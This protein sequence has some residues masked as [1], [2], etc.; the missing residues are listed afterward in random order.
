MK[1]NGPCNVDGLR[2]RRNDGSLKR[3]VIGVLIACVAVTVMTAGATTLT[4]TGG[5]VTANWSDADNWDTG[6]T[7]I[8][9]VDLIFDGTTQQENVNDIGNS[10]LSRISSLTVNVDGFIISGNPLELGG[11][12]SV[13]G[14]TTWAINSTL[15]QAISITSVT[16][17]T[18]TLS[19]TLN[20]N[21]YLL[22]LLGGGNFTFSGAISGSGGLTLNGT[23]TATLS[24]A[25]SFSGLTTIAS[26][27]LKM[28]VA[29]AI[30]RLTGFTFNY[31]NC[32][33]AGGI[34]DLNGYNLSCN[35]V[36]GYGTVTSSSG[37]PVLTVGSSESAYN[38]DGFSG[39]ITGPVVLT[40]DG[41]N[42]FYLDGG[43]NNVYTGNTTVS[44]GTLQ[45]RAANSIARGSG[46]GNLSISS[47]A[48]LDLKGW[49]TGVNGLSGAGQ[50]I[51]SSDATDAIFTV[52]NGNATSVFPGIMDD[53][54]GTFKVALTKTGTGALTLS[55]V[56]NYRGAT[57]VGGGQLVVN[58]SLSSASAVAVNAG[59]TLSGNGT[60]GGTV[61][62]ANST[63]AVLYPNSSSTLTVGGNT[64]FN[65][66]NS[67]T[68]FDLSSSAASGND[69]VVLQSQT[70]AITGSPHV[71]INSAGSLDT[72]DYVLFDAG[73]SG[74][75]SG[76]FNTI[77]TWTG[78]TPKFAA[79]YTVT[80]V[81][82]TV[83]LHYTTIPLTVTA[84][85][86][87][88]TYDGNTSASA[89]PTRTSGTLDSGDTGSFTESYDTPNVGSSKTL[90]PTGTIKDAGN[91]DVTSR[92][93]I[94]WTAANV[95]TITAAITPIIVSGSRIYNGL[96]T[97]QAS[98]LTI[99][100][101][102][103]GAN[104][105]LSGTA[106]LASKS[107][108]AQAVSAGTLALGG[109]AA[110]NYTLVGMSGS[111]TITAKDA[112]LT[113]LGASDKF[114][115]GTTTATL[116]GTAA[117]TS[118]DIVSGDDVSLV[119]GVTP[120]GAFVDRELGNA[121]SVPYS[122][123]FSLSGTD[124][125]NYHLVLQSLTA[126]IVNHKEDSGTTTITSA[127]SSTFD[128]WLNNGK[129]LAD[130]SP[131]GGSINGAG[132][133][134]VN[135]TAILGGTGKVG[136]VT[137][138]S[139]G[140]LAP[141]DNVGALS[142]G[143]ETW[144]TNGAYAFQMSS[145][146]GTGGP[147][148]DLVSITGNLNIAATI[149]NAFTIKLYTLSGGA[150]GQGAN[151]DNT[152]DYQWPIATVSGS[153]ASF[154]ATKFVVDS[155]QF[156]NDPGSGKFSI[157]L[158]PDQKSVDLVFSQDCAINLT[159]ST[160]AIGADGKVHMYFSNPFGFTT[161][162]GL[163]ARILN[164][165]TITGAM[166][167]GPGFDSGLS[168]DGLPL[169]V[170][171]QS[172]SISAGATRLEVVATKINGSQ[173]ATVNVEVRDACGGQ[174]NF[175]P[176]FTELKVQQGGVVRQ[177]F[178]NLPAAEHYVGVVNGTPGLAWLSI[179]VNGQVF[180]LN[181]LADGQSV[182]LDLGAA[183]G[184]GNTNVVVLAGQGV[185]GASASITIGDLSVVTGALTPAAVVTGTAAQ[186]WSSLAMAGAN[187]VLQITQNGANLVLSWP[188]MWDGFEVQTRASMAPDASWVPVEV[189][190]EL[191]NGR[192]TVTVPAISGRFFRLS[193]PW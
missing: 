174:G 53:S 186:H 185:A 193:N 1:L 58:G 148:W 95:G 42:L 101:N 22:T 74:T 166:A 113:G 88:K 141:G 188:D 35:A 16:G 133:I 127:N 73:S 59:G 137:V 154:D 161:S 132:T 79:G 86:N 29:N 71:T 76:S 168:L 124:A 11:S 25:N 179:L 34:L 48:T 109:S 183:M 14:N 18:L 118:G 114:Y 57:I 63:T 128:L 120:T 5:G 142:T 78:T 51:N 36:I 70:L 30:P 55:G 163:E 167:Y 175:D 44:A 150:P 100:N 136:G 144:N 143:S 39:A 110:A 8:T 131:A 75:I 134:T 187:P 105:T 62:V 10:T 3:A 96:A 45:M 176:T 6:T 31:I 189:T 80:T 68:K 155:S 152:R 112:T 159:T 17:G 138:N 33:G 93:N 91:N 184:E 4:W 66:V 92:Y 117:I 170:V 102:L 116:T 72:A 180:A 41:T 15:N 171:G 9:G 146:T 140:I 173:S 89:T 81:G 85:N 192:F 46:K 82:R 94:T 191:A 19:G 165:C 135:T 123:D 7:P 50:V 43:F 64:A 182:L 164:N 52:G 83:V 60:V 190:P 145:A 126:S 119:S 160:Y 61:T 107:V 178:S 54:G 27:T 108:G 97:A 87:S 77:P 181:P 84:T 125:S 111:V 156:L 115:D 162:G 40:K 130:N 151:F 158:S 2:Q 20:N 32:S 98:I 67:K 172:T 26:G 104:L 12:W 23:G 99:S 139:G 37:S 13:T 122:S 149:T 38:N 24:T 103:D 21:S 65:G 69:K 90:T 157:R 121:K 177:S 47:G 129:V 28:G 106:N 153:I 147:D 49:A 169:T 56:N